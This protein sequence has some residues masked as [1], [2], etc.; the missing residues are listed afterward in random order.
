M[1]T[2]P[3]AYDFQSRASG[4]NAIHEGQKNG[5]SPV[6]TGLDGASIMIVSDVP[7]KRISTKGKP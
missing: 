3:E 1:T 5:L 7:S 4:A 6:L 2:A